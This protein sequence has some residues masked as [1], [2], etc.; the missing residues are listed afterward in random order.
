MLSL[1]C[2]QKETA[3]KTNSK[4]CNLGSWSQSTMPMNLHRIKRKWQSN[5]GNELVARSLEMMNLRY[6]LVVSHGY[7]PLSM[8]QHFYTPH[9]RKKRLK[10]T[11]R[12]VA[13]H[14]RNVIQCTTG[15]LHDVVCTNNH[16]GDQRLSPVLVVDDESRNKGATEYYMQ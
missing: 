15:S 3:N 4:A 14:C 5:R 16:R 6:A 9:T 1:C 12:T 13:A 8:S 7:A 2:P 11:P 10:F